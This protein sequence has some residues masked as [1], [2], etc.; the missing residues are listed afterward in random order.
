MTPVDTQTIE[1]LWHRFKS[2]TSAGDEAITSQELEKVMRSLGHHPSEAELRH[3]LLEVDATGH[4]TFEKFKALV[5]AS[6]GDRDSRLRIAFDVFDEN[7]DGLVTANEL[8]DVLGQFGMT[9][10][11]LRQILEGADRDG[12]GALDFEEFQAFMPDER[13][14]PA[15]RY[16]SATLPHP[17]SSEDTSKVSDGEAT[18]EPQPSTHHGRAEAGLGTSRLQMQISLFRLLQGAAYRSFR[19]NYSANHATHLR[20]KKLPYTFPHFVGFVE[21]AMALYKALGIVEPACHPLLDA[22]TQSVRAEYDRLTDRIAN[23]SKVEKT[24]QMRAAEDV[25]RQRR[26]GTENLRE[27]FAAGVEFALTLRKKNLGLADVVEDLLALH[28]LSRL[29]RLELHHEL[30]GP[31]TAPA[32]DPASYLAAWNPVI[33]ASADEEVDGAML[34]AAYWYEDFMPKLLAAFSVATADDIPAN[35]IPDEAALDRWFEEAR[36]AGEFSHYGTD[37]A[38]HFPN[39][40]PARKLAIKQAWRL[41][42]HYLN[43]VQKRRERLEFGRESGFLSQYVAFLDVYLGRSDV[44]DAQMR[45]SFPYY[46][47][48]AVWRF[49][50]TTAEIVRARSPS[51]QGGLVRLF[52][53]FFK[54]FATM[55]P[56]PYC[57]YHLNAYVVQNGEV[58]MYPMEYLLLGWA[59]DHRNLQVSLE[60]KLSSIEDG[61]SLRLFLWKLHNCVS[62]SIARMEPWY[63]RDDSAF[64]TNRYWPS[65][66]AE[67]TRSR[68]LNHEGVPLNRLIPI[69]GLLKPLANLASLRRN[70]RTSLAESA[71][72]DLPTTCEEARAAI[73]SVEAALAKGGFLETTYAFDPDLEDEA[74]HFTP[75]EEAFGRSGGFVEA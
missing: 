29:R 55:Y 27:K 17:T 10:E 22:V 62:S 73:A 64:Y 36:S 75:E 69:Y 23:W 57:R 30:T 72:E 8:G 50:H 35:T 28:E 74:P 12:D 37:V 53:D 68:A 71:A 58:E 6:H 16:V 46:L 49:F 70:L 11:E 61:P 44:R 3:M 5:A 40:D 34:P 4:V 56:C 19:E 60:D 15:E 63:H 39:C 43:G 66:D 13:S 18:H 21:T 25:M 2:Q 20:A 45:V 59:P 9:Q 48:P 52:K 38:Q 1:E 51:E 31:T 33:M 14:R 65:L 24:P 67:I 32:A 42:R 26:S 54:L 47:G 41:T 7:G